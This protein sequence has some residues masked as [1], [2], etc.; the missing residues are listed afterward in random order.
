MKIKKRS[1]S[2]TKNNYAVPFSTSHNDVDINF[3]SIQAGA[4]KYNRSEINYNVKNINPNNE[5]YNKN[6]RMN[7]KHETIVDNRE[8][9]SKTL[10]KD[11]DSINDEYYQNSENNLKSLSRNKQ[12]PETKV[13]DAKSQN[14][15]KLKMINKKLCF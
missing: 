11:R 14:I 4:Y 8:R 1:N 2:T 13:I 3:K 6:N 5:H 9:K 15:E 12:L 7:L 10:N